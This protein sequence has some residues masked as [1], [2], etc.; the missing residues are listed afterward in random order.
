MIWRHIELSESYSPNIRLREDSTVLIEAATQI[1]KG[2]NL[3]MEAVAHL[4]INLPR[5][6]KVR[7]AKDEAVVDQKMT[8]GDV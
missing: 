8:I 6:I 3:V 7:A 2:R 4:A 5:I 1:K